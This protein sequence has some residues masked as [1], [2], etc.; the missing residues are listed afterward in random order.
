AKVRLKLGIQGK[1]GKSYVLR[2][3]RSG[4]A[5]AK[6]GKLKGLKVKLSS[7]KVKITGIPKAVGKRQVKSVS[8]AV[9]SLYKVPRG[10]KKK[11]TFK[12]RAVVHGGIE[13]T[14]KAK[15]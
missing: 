3:A 6:K 15:Q 2:P 1:G 13:L 10:K 8:L 5:R 14:A 7:G 9:G 11:A 4:V 12:A